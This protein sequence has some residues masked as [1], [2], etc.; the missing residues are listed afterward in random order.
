MSSRRV[1]RS[2]KLSP[3]FQGLLEN[4]HGPSQ[5]NSGT[6]AEH[7]TLAEASKQ[8][9]DKLLGRA[10]A[11][12]AAAR[13]K[14]SAKPL[15]TQKRGRKNAFPE[16]EDSLFYQQNI[17]NDGRSSGNSVVCGASAST[18]VEVQYGSSGGQG[19]VAP[20]SSLSVAEAMEH[21]T[22]KVSMYGLSALNEVQDS[23]TKGND[24]LDECTYM[25]DECEWEL[26]AAVSA[27]SDREDDKLRDGEFN[28]EVDMGTPEILERKLGKRVLRRANAK[29]KEFA[30]LVHKTHLLCLIA[31][32][33]LVDA[34][35]DDPVLQASLLS[36]V[37]G[38]IHS[39]NTQHISTSELGPFVKWFQSAFRIHPDKDF[40][41]SSGPVSSTEDLISHFFNALHK[42]AG[43]S[44]QVAA[45]SVS[46][47]RALGFTARYVTVLDVLS[48]KPDAS[49]LEASAEWDASHAAEGAFSQRLLSARLASSL[50][51]VFSQCAPHT[52]ATAVTNAMPSPAAS[53]PNPSR[54]PSL[55]GGRKKQELTRHQSTNGKQKV[56]ENSN[57][58]S[59]EYQVGR[60]KKLKFE[61]NH[62]LHLCNKEE[63]MDDC[64]DIPPD[65]SEVHEQETK[66][67]KKGDVE[68][69][70]QLAMAMAATT[71]TDCKSNSGSIGKAHKNSKNEVEGKSNV[72]NV[73]KVSEKSE[74]R[75][76]CVPSKRIGSAAT[77]EKG[78]VQYNNTASLMT[79]GSAVWSRKL[80]PLLHWAEVYCGGKDSGRWVHVDAGR[81]L[82]DSAEV[83]ESAA[84]S[85]KV[86]LR[87]VLAFAGTGAKDVTRRYVT[88]WS[89]V[90]PLR[91]S[92]DWWSATLA[93]LK[94]LEAAGTS[95]YVNKED[96]AVCQE[97]K[98]GGSTAFSVGS[99]SKV[100]SSSSR[101]QVN[102][103]RG[104]LEDMELDIRT[105]TEPLPRNQQAYK[106]H[107]LYVLERW[108]TKYQALHPRGPIL[109]YCAGHPV[110]PR[111]CVQDLHTAERWLREGLKVKP[112]ELPAKTV[113][114]PRLVAK[115][116]TDNSF[117]A[118]EETT[119]EAPT[120]AL[121]G[122]WQTEPW[123]P[124]PAVGGIVPKNERGNVELWSEK[125]LP[126]GT[127]HISLPRI[128]PVAKKLE[129]DFAQALVGFEIRNRRSVPV[130][131]GIIVCQEHEM[132]LLEAYAEEEYRRN[133]EAEKKR[134]S[135]AVARWCQLLRSITTRQRLQ[136][137]YQIPQEAPPICGS[138]AIDDEQ[139]Q[140]I[141]LSENQKANHKDDD[142][143]NQHI[144]HEHMFPE[145]NQSYDERT[146]IRT[147]ICPCGFTLTVEEM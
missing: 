122:K 39:H 2:S 68:F 119:N 54:R 38:H 118:P 15:T 59:S 3:E 14:G 81:G 121:F 16:G 24:A 86:P 101:P 111:A 89:A 92:N 132:I 125:C 104:S 142:K 134:E 47:L 147:K 11:R 98:L 29:D 51:Q 82:L 105:C 126:P 140:T 137:T 146:G 95:I 97:D 65:V 107:H 62:D 4:L 57:S 33:R 131:E 22:A 99:S 77:I 102:N 133:V 70:L 10:G 144:A 87:Y 79:S 110:F 143:K 13:V 145:E 34:A 116:N 6:V 135:L 66:A 83:V 61:D 45:L 71:T 53:S 52:L 37:P 88:L 113:K 56:S 67:K 96:E 49:S 84:R 112:H 21:D 44:E 130:F 8:D 141:S 9:V 28:I 129:I 109:G 138:S 23:G 103:D 106:N 20:N 76:D 93:P 25:E 58:L 43:S 32:G 30:E 7:S 80:G 100:D 127:V 115:Q 94:E 124:P 42:Q 41:T 5:E 128:L 72:S 36:I 60:Y 85:C 1:T 69:E 120:T 27:G 108:L 18:R 73:G 50:G 55:E 139:A 35:C 74:N 19:V 31:R 40:T 75:V 46:L 17:K 26:G 48:L 12:G 114:N 117:A 78:K 90:A 63:A 91:V 136:A 64:R 123:H